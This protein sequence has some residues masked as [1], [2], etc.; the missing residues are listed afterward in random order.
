MNFRGM[1]RLR[2]NAFRLC[3]DASESI[4][5]KE[6]PDSKTTNNATA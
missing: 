2:A 4:N 5:L 3:K 6:V 1:H